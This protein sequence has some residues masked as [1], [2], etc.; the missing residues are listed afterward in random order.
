MGP[1]IKWPCNRRKEA[2][3]SKATDLAPISG[4]GILEWGAY[5]WSLWGHILSRLLKLCKVIRFSDN[6]QRNGGVFF[7]F[8]VAPFRPQ[9]QGQVHCHRTGLLLQECGAWGPSCCRFNITCRPSVRKAWT[10]HTSTS[11]VQFTGSY[12]WHRACKREFVTFWKRV[13]KC[14]ERLEWR[15]KTRKSPKIQPD[16]LLVRKFAKYSECLGEC[17]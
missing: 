16:D 8:F 10:K 13:G 7:F 17:P 3:R 14:W 1:C 4:R 2:R 11:L 5:W 15:L 9:S 12:L 6:K